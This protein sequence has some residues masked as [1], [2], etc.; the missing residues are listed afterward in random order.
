MNHSGLNELD[1]LEC[2]LSLVEDETSGTAGRPNVRRVSQLYTFTVAIW[3]S[4]LTF[5][6]MF[7]CRNRSSNSGIISR[8]D[9]ALGLNMS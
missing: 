8:G 4:R 3:S 1:A 5:G 6:L 2:F 9:F 7:L